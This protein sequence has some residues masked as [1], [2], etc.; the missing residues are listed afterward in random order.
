LIRRF[1]LFYLLVG[2]PVDLIELGS[3]VIDELCHLVDDI[4]HFSVQIG[5]VHHRHPVAHVHAVHAVDHVAGVV[6]VEPVSSAA[7]PLCGIGVRAG[8]LAQTIRDV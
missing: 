3:R 5:L 2:D 6:G 1:E 7:D 4:G 8:L